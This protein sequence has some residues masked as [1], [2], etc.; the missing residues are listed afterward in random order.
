[1]ERY[2]IED[3]AFQSLA[4]ASASNIG[5]RDID[6]GLVQ[7]AE[8]RREVSGRTPQREGHRSRRGGSR[9]QSLGDDPGD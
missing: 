9:G 6:A 7:S 4:R 5:L 2:Q 1:M 3:R 8:C